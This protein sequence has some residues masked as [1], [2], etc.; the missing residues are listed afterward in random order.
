MTENKKVEVL[1][2]NRMPWQV[3][4]TSTDKKVFGQKQLIQDPDIG[5]ES[6]LYE[7][8]AGFTTYMHTH[9]CGHGHFILEGQ[10][11]VNQ[12][13]YGPGTFIW[14]PEGCVAE[15]GATAFEHAKVLMFSNKPFKVNYCKDE[16]DR[17]SREK[18]IEPILV[19]TNRMEWFYRMASTSGKLFS[20]KALHQDKDTGMEINLMRYPAGFTTECHAHPCSQGFY[21]IQGQFH[22]D[23]MIYGPGT[24]LWYPEGCIAE[25]G[26][27]AYEDCVCI[28]FSN[29]PQKMLYERPE[30]Q[31]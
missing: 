2:T 31:K 24:M 13:Y 27:T 4:P 11:K 18:G 15:H 1:D 6:A 10:M 29:K 25:H 28:Q 20:K 12:S 21:I 17:Q 23:Q 14:Y 22:S 30:Y 7:Y 5:M 26:A 8:P 9:P 19:D 16:A 3:C